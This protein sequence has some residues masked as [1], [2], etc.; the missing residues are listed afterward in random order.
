MLLDAS[1]TDKFSER[2]PGYA[3]NEDSNKGS[4]AKKR[5]LQTVYIPPEEQEKLLERYRHVVVQ[6]FEDGYHMSVEEREKMQKENKSFFILKK[7]FTKKIRKLDKFIEAYRVCLDIIDE[8]ANTNGIYDPDKFREMVFSGK[9]KINGLDFPKF[10]GK[11]KKNINWKF[12]TQ[13]IENKN[14]DISSIFNNDDED[15][16]IKLTDDRELIQDKELEYIL[17]P[18]TKEEERIADRCVTDPEDAAN[19]GA[20]RISNKGQHKKFMKRYP[21][22]VHAVKNIYSDDTRSNIHVWDLEES[23]LEAIQEYDALYGKKGAGI[24]RPVFSGNILKQSDVDA[25]LF[26]VKQY[27]DATQLVE[28]NGRYITRDEYENIKL[29]EEL[30]SAGYNIRNLYDNRKK[31]KALEKAKENDR[32]RIKKLRNMLAE[33]QKRSDKRE[34]LGE[35]IDSKENGG[36]NKKKKKNKKGKKKAKAYDRIILDAAGVGDKDMKSYKKRM[37]NMK[38]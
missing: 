13:C 29:K 17:R 5:E 28:Y 22:F 30:E 8:I 25:Y 26:A 32:K 37:K 23:Q 7:N 21:Q 33:V 6:D 19:H 18:M 15:D 2:N 27:E 1:R 16:D 9:I 10:Q 3:S 38:L 11:G 12:V 36:V 4:P 24:Q 14:I 35:E 34:E 20:A 31:E